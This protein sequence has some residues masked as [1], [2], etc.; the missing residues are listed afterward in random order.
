[1]KTEMTKSVGFDKF[2][3]QMGGTC[4]FV[5][6]HAAGCCTKMRHI[7]VDP[8]TAAESTIGF[9]EKLTQE[10]SG[11][12]WAPRGPEY[13]FMFISCLDKSFQRANEPF[14]R[15]IGEAE[16]VLGKDL[17]TPLQLPW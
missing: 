5:S 9:V 10:Q 6:T 2:Y 16:R 13:V 14:G 4:T 12:F 7:A 17:P 15:G 1:M 11:T 3:D 8:S